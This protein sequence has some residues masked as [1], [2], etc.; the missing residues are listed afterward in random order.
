MRLGAGRFKKGDAIDHS[1]GLILHAKMGDYVS[2]GEPLVEIHARSES[3]IVSIRDSLLSAYTWSET[4]VEHQ[5]LI[6]DT[7]R[8]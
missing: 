8:P 5:P 6:Y 7:V 2:A 4:P 1:T 3:D